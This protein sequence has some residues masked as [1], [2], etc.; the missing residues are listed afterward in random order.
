VRLHRLVAYAQ[1]FGVL[2]VLAAGDDAFEHLRLAR[3]QLGQQRVAALAAR[4]VTPGIAVVIVGED[5]ASHVY[6]KSK[7]KAAA[8]VG[9]TSFDHSLPAHV[10]QTHLLG[11]VAELAGDTRVHGILVQLPLPKHIDS[12]AILDAIPPE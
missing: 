1:V 3:C 10:T 4:G 12:T 9:V 5:P 11:L 8:E 2:I 7:H 6:V